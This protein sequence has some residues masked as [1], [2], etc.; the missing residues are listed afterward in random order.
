[1]SR[2]IIS[3]YGDLPPDWVCLGGRR[4]PG[5][6]GMGR[7]AASAR[8]DRWR[9]THEPFPDGVGSFGELVLAGSCY[10]PLPSQMHSHS[11]K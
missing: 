10:L 1:M 4:W 2:E 6:E 5:P 11:A 8:A 9:W 7:A 3:G